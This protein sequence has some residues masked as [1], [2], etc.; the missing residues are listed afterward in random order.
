MKLISL[1]KQAGVTEQSY[2]SLLR[3]DVV[4]FMRRRRKGRGSFD[5]EHL[6]A[7]KTFALLRS[8]GISSVIAGSAVAEAYPAICDLVQ[9]GKLEPPRSYKIGV[10]FVIHKGKRQA[11]LLHEAA[12][13]DW[14]ELCRVELDLRGVSRLLPAE[15]SIAE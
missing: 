13:P 12:P 4:P 6:V 1:L 2:Y 3:Q 11:K 10:R 8:H 7:M 9:K 5:R 14:L 15:G